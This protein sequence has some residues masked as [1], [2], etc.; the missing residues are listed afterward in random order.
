MNAN[1]KAE[2]D[3]GSASDGWGSAPFDTDDDDAG[4]D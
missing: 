4:W 2:D 1:K 3:F